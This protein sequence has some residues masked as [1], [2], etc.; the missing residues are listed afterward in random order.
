MKKQHKYEKNMS[1][2]KNVSE[3]GWS[4][5]THKKKHHRR[6]LQQKNVI[7]QFKRNLERSMEIIKF[8]SRGLQRY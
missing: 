5:R 1:C 2:G 6:V 7:Q 3:E 4:A 8:Y